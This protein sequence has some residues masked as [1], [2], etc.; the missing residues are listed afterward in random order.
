VKGLGVGHLHAAFPWTASARDRVP[1]AAV[2]GSHELWHEVG[3]TAETVA[4]TNGCHGLPWNNV[5]LC[6][7]CP[8]LLEPACLVMPHGTIVAASIP[9]PGVEG[10]LGAF[11][12]PVC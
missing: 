2:V 11:F 1:Y 4:G 9:F 7:V 10:T 12:I 8:G 3:I 6:D 5:M